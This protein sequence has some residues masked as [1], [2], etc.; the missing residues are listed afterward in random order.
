[1]TYRDDIGITYIRI[2]YREPRESRDEKE[3]IDDREL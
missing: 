2:T 1:M 3:P